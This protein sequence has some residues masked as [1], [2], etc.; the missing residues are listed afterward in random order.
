MKK[1]L[2]TNIFPKKF[3]KTL[4]KKTS[5]KK[6]KVKKY[7][8]SLLKKNSVKRYE[9][10]FLE[11][12]II[13][14][15]KDLLGKKKSRNKFNDYMSNSKPDKKSKNLMLFLIRLAEVLTASIIPSTIGL[16]IVLITPKTRIMQVME[17][18]S[19]MAFFIVSCIFWFKYVKYRRSRVEFYIMHSAV[20]A[21]YAGLSVIVYSLSDVYLYSIFF[22][23]LRGFEI[24]GYKTIQSMAITHLIMVL[25][26]I[27]CEILA[28]IYYKYKDKKA[29][30]NSIEKPEIES[31][32]VTPKQDNQE[33][34]F[35]SVDELNIEID[36]EMQE[37][38]DIIRS[39]YENVS[40]K[41]WNYDMVQG[42][43]GRIV[44]VVPEDPEN[45]IDDADFVSEAYA[46]EEMKVTENYSEESLWNEDIYKGE[47]PTYDYDREEYTKEEFSKADENSMWDEEMH[48]GNGESIQY[49][50]DDDSD[51]MT[52]FEIYNNEL[53]KYTKNDLDDYDPDN[54][55]GEIKQGR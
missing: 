51:D 35:L 54:L 1:I 9:F 5:K 18:I 11:K 32:A 13:E 48:K 12:R 8:D 29:A 14:I 31:I 7:T 23:D 24:F 53:N 26:M 39:E 30:E 49:S 20:Y 21:L 28:H 4:S 46:R 2:W 34:K 19:F 44:E 47:N 40:D 33:V 42:K 22:S 3:N 15:F 43:N 25:C 37:A 41:N 10:L 6:D 55:W 38:A 27:V 16:I 36:R 50:E 17:C 45:D 52:F